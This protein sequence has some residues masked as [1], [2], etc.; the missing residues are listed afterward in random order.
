MNIESI[1]TTHN[2]INFRSRLEARWTIVFEVLETKYEYEPQLFDFGEIKY[3]PD[4]W[5]PEHKRWIEIKGEMPTKV[6]IQKAQLLSE[7]T[8]Q[9]VVILSGL[10]RFNT[11]VCNY[12][13]NYHHITIP[14]GVG[15]TYFK[16]GKNS[17]TPLH[18]QIDEFMF[19]L[20][21]KTPTEYG[22][23]VD[24]IKSN[25]SRLN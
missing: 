10:F 3:I 5:L 4:F 11:F 18:I 23:H 15:I 1:E 2:G 12:C 13:S 8:K 24:L 17:F 25:C 20:L 6:Q 16:G 7:E 9:D 21:G 22:P 19:W 14:S